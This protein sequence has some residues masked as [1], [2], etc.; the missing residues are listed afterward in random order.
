MTKIVISK[1]TSSK[2]IS[3]VV[4]MHFART[5]KEFQSL[6]PFWANTLESKRKLLIISSSGE[7]YFK[8][9]CQITISV[10]KIKTLETNLVPVS[11][12]CTL[13]YKVPVLFEKSDG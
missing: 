9:I 4:C 2:Y 7:F 10:K 13:P 12:K 11:L 1:K 3:V 5:F 8:V 6:F